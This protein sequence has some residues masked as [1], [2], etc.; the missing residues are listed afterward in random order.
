MPSQVVQNLA[1]PCCLASNS[2]ELRVV[3]AGAVL[4]DAE[5]EEIPSIAP[6]RPPRSLGRGRE[7]KGRKIQEIHSS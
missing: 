2:W 1:P 3:H 6:Q 5:S 4:E 7:K